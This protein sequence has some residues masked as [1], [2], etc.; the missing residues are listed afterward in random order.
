MKSANEVYLA[1]VERLE[2]ELMPVDRDA[3]LTSIAISLKRIVDYLEGSPTKLGLLESLF[4]I[5]SRK[6]ARG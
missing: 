5:D 6:D 3:A 4:E 2:P 1:V